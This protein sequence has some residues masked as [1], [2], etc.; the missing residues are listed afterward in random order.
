MVTGKSCQVGIVLYLYKQ[1]VLYLVQFLCYQNRTAQNLWTA[2]KLVVELPFGLLYRSHL[3]VLFRMQLLI[4]RSGLGAESLR[5]SPATW[6]YGC[7]GSVFESENCLRV[8]VTTVKSRKYCQSPPWTTRATVSDEANVRKRTWGSGGKF[9]LGP[10]KLSLPLCAFH[11]SPHP[12]PNSSS[13]F[14]SSVARD[15]ADCGEIVLRWIKKQFS[16]S[17][18]VSETKRSHK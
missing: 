6:W 4:G 10:E 7:C 13:H 18:F 2:S 1:F 12:T 15:C 16:K 14:T 17:C 9:S 8:V 3:G 5:F 11:P